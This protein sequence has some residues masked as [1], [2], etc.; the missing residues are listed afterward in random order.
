LITYYIKT[1]GGIKGN[2]ENSL[3]EYTTQSAERLIQKGTKGIASWSKAI[4][5]HDPQKYA[6]FDARVSIS[7]NCLQI[8]FNTDNKILYPIL[9]SQNK[10]ITK[11]NKIIK[12]LAKNDKWNKANE[13]KF[14]VDYLNLLG[15]IASEIKTE[16]APIEMLLFAKAE[17]LINIVLENVYTH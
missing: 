11:G 15:S 10:T 6:I 13:N 4:C 1:W 14:Y 5:I 17:E 3:N 12:T 2:K 9:L 7:L 8:I 16:I